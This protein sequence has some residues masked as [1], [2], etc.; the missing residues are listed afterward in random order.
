MN[1]G[2]L[3]LD[4]GIATGWSLLKDDGEFTTGVVSLGPKRG[5]THGPRY[6]FLRAFLK[7]KIEEGRVSLVVYEQTLGHHKS[8][9]QAKL[10]NGL[11]GVL[12]EEAAIYDVELLAVPNGTLKKWATGSGR[13]KKPQMIRAAWDRWPNDR[14]KWSRVKPNKTWCKVSAKGKSVVDQAL[15]ADLDYVTTRGKC[16][17]DNQVDAVWLANYAVH[18][19]A[20][21]IVPRPPT[22]PR[23]TEQADVFTGEKIPCAECGGEIEKTSYYCLW[24]HAPKTPEEWVYK[25]PSC[26]NKQDAGI[27]RK[28]AEAKKKAK[29][30]KLKVHTGGSAEGQ[31]E[32]W[33]T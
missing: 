31:T 28:A 9:Q 7:K 22:Q 29:K 19:L 17:D 30:T 24:A 1:G 5:D 23:Y 3:T 27:N 26:L 13:A 18:T 33:G 32:F 12:E 15:V 16:P 20:M 4:L 11:V 2:L 25:H 10:S 21:E 8:S 6:M 14:K